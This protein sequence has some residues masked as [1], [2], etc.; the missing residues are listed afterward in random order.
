M[1]TESLL[2][3]L[4]TATSSD[5][6]A[7]LV[8]EA[9]IDDLP[10]SVAKV[11]LQCGFLP[12]FSTEVINSL[13]GINE[14]N[15]KKIELIANLPF[16][17]HLA[18]GYCF[19]AA[20][21]IGL[22]KKYLQ[23]DP[24]EIEGAF[25]SSEE[26]FNNLSQSYIQANMALLY[27]YV[28]T[29]K[30]QK[31]EDKLIEILKNGQI[32]DF[33]EIDEAEE[34]CIESNAK[35]T[36][37]YWAYKAQAHLLKVEIEKV[38][39][40]CNNA[41]IIDDTYYLAYSIRGLANAHK[42]NYDDALH[43][44]NY[45]IQLK[46]DEISYRLRAYIHALRGDLRSAIFDYTR[47]I[48][49][50]PSE[51]FS[52]LGRARIYLLLNKP[53]KSVI[54]LEDAIK[55]SSDDQSLS[56]AHSEYAAILL[57]DNKLDEAVRHLD[58][59]I[60]NDPSSG[61]YRR[62]GDIHIRL[63]QLDLARESF[64]QAI[65]LDP[66]NPYAYL[67]RGKLLLIDDAYSAA[68]NDFQMANSLKVHGKV[69]TY[70][71]SMFGL[72]EI[73]LRMWETFLKLDEAQKANQQRDYL[74]DTGLTVRQ[75]LELMMFC[76][77]YKQFESLLK[78]SD[79]Y[80]SKKLDERAS[81]FG[82]TSAGYAL[83]SLNRY[84]DAL[85]YLE[86]NQNLVIDFVNI[87]ISYWGLKNFS[88]ALEYFEEANSLIPGRKYKKNNLQNVSI[89]TKAWIALMIGDSI[90]A[91]REIRSYLN[92]SV[93]LDDLY[94]LRDWM[95]IVIQSNNIPVGLQ[96]FSTLVNNTLIDLHRKSIF[97]LT[98]VLLDE[99]RLVVSSRK[100]FTTK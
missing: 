63:N 89:P 7:A 78:V 62:K 1:S 43:D 17:E 84:A 66:E 75:L 64:E 95:A 76:R 56:F 39:R 53:Q 21:R 55:V 36:P 5:Q 98:P 97:T 60:K 31:A 25:N 94:N 42:E 15:P 18:E 20:A 82:Y 96:E 28:I 35:L 79:L 14:N 99:A 93:D 50:N 22:I 51:I 3:N 85:G 2:E 11:A 80:L 9:I 72:K 67:G 61:L 100:R 52:Y 70:T 59:A 92:S 19:H 81:I 38:I 37:K 41:L 33:S 74:L 8:V 48:R 54:D 68:L 6:K 30:G 44:A 32:D 58:E 65:S 13:L 23:Y 47:A 29:N 34:N 57:L 90:R 91:V 83:N 46:A 71:D 27:G 87:A 10:K 26:I 40:A 24:S 77:K 16:V 86:K 88:K 73:D 49:V 69:L 4:K 12:W 45:A